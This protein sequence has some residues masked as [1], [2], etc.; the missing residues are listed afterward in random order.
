M[1]TYITV[2]IKIPTDHKFDSDEK[3]ELQE[4][5]ADTITDNLTC[6]GWNIAGLGLTCEVTVK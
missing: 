4:A 1:T 5:I 3:Q 6:D 2:Q